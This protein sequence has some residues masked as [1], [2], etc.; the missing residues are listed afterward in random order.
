MATHR[1][2]GAAFDEVVYADDTICMGN[3]HKTAKQNA[4]T[5]RDRRPKIRKITK[6]KQ[7]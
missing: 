5:H 3:R 4:E 1:V 7:V 6:R 2:P